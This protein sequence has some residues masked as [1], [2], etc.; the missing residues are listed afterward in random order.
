MKAERKKLKFQEEGGKIGKSCSWGHKSIYPGERWQ[1]SS[2]TEEGPRVLSYQEE[3][4]NG[5]LN[6]NTSGGWEG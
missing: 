6:A 5:G 1:D 3:R 4:G 2:S